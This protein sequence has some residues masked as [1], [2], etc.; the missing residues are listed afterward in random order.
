[1]DMKYKAFIALLVLQLARTLLVAAQDLP[2]PPSDEEFSMIKQEAIGELHYGMSRT[3]ALKY[4]AAK[5]QFDKIMDE[6]GAVSQIVEFVEAGIQLELISDEIT[7][8]QRVN[9]I[10]VAAPC[11]LKTKKG[12][13][14]GSSEAEVVAAYKEHRDAEASEAG[15]FF[16]AGS[17][18]DGLMFSIEN[19]KVVRIFIGSIVN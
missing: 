5:P 6:P 4:V 12:I 9:F 1:M 3:D 8:P 16:V 15:K 10:S 11:A 18:Y 17:D 19:G 13:H 2:E 7:S 14:I